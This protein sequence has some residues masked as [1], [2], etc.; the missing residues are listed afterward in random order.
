MAITFRYQ[1]I[2]GKGVSLK[3]PMINVTFSNGSEVFKTM[4][5]LDSGADMSAISSDIAEIIGI[6]T[7]G[8]RTTIHGVAGKV[9]SIQKKVNVSFGNEHERYSF[10]IP[11]KVVFTDESDSASFIPLLG[12]DGFFNQFKITFDEANLKFSLKKNN[13]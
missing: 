5:L 8:E 10:N 1:M 12:R 11:V 6:D 13:D 4:A 9:E 2:N 3:R 7:D